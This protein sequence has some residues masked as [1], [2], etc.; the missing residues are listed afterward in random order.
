MEEVMGRKKV[1]K[2]TQEQREE[3]ERQTE[4]TS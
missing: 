4:L 3:K 2:G 1:E